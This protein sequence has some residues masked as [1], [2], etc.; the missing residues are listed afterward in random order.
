MLGSASSL[1]CLTKVNYYSFPRS[2]YAFVE[3]LMYDFV[4]DSESMTVT[5]LIQLLTVGVQSTPREVGFGH[6]ACNH[7]RYRRL[8]FGLLSA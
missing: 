7:L 5:R 6:V 8:S 4:S 1:D 3:F 2:M